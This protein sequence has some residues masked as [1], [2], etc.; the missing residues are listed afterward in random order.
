MPQ[1]EMKQVVKQLL[2]EAGIPLYKKDIMKVYYQNYYDKSED[3][4]NLPHRQK[5]FV[6]VKKGII[7]IE[8]ETQEGSKYSPNSWRWVTTHIRFNGGECL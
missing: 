4:S 8:R 2:A 6:M 1:K 7:I 3:G 5:W